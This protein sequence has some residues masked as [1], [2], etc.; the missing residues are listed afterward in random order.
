MHVVL[1]QYY[2][3][4]IQVHVHVHVPYI[5]VHVFKMDREQ[6]CVHVTIFSIE[7]HTCRPSGLSLEN[8]EGFMKQQTSSFNYIT[9]N[10]SYSCTT[11]IYSSTC[12]C[13]HMHTSIGI[14]CTF[15]FTYMQLD[16]LFFSFFFKLEMDL[17]RGRY[18]TLRVSA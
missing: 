16:S 5:H 1:I 10:Y 15:Q 9:R 3:I 7:I 11:C 12:T 13:M 14:T 18:E 8:H 2:I 17:Q 6:K 4:C